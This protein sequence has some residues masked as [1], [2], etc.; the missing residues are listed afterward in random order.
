MPSI[1]SQHAAL[2]HW[3]TQ[4]DCLQVAGIPLT[5]IAE[6]VG[7]TPFYVYDRL[8]VAARIAD[9]REHLPERIELHYAVKANPMPA[10]VGFIAPRVDGLDVAS[11]GELTV[12][13]DAGMAP[14]NISFAGPGKH[15]SELRQAIAAG[16]LLNVESAREVSLLARLS[17]ALQL[18][19]RV[20]V[21][22]N[23]DFELKS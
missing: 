18:P 7:R 13:L 22:V 9:L 16:V 4:H 1:E 10:L 15:E 6:R 11:A 14:A 21:R 3:P 12:A 5:Q 23:P 2:E 17:Q 20:A 19:A 8:R